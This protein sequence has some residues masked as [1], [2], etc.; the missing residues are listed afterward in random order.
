MDIILSVKAAY[1]MEKMTLIKWGTPDTIPVCIKCFKYLLH[2]H[3][4]NK[5][6]LVLVR[7]YISQ[8]DSDNASTYY[9]YVN[10]ISDFSSLSSISYTA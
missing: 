7:N 1:R 3:K 4:Y 2:F 8:S 9:V 6:G 10:W 5:N